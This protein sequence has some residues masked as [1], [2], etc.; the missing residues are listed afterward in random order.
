MTKWNLL[1]PY[2][3]VKKLSIE[4]FVFTIFIC[5]RVNVS[6]YYVTGSINTEGHIYPYFCYCAGPVGPMCLRRFCVGPVCP[7][8]LCRYSMGP[9]DPVSLWSSRLSSYLG[10]YVSCAARC[11]RLLLACCTE[12]LLKA[13]SIRQGTSAPPPPPEESKT[14]LQ[15][16]VLTVKLQ[17]A[18]IQPSLSA[19]PCTLDTGVHHVHWACCLYKS[20]HYSKAGRC[21]L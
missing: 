12:R 18:E 4:R 8:S 1:F 21:P 11:F 20:R 5:Y 3:S 19:S 13:P 16:S 17:N 7:L 6:S 2:C 9:A 15:A 14:R 10:W